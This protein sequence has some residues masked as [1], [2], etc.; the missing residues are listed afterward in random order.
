M[1]QRRRLRTSWKIITFALNLNYV[2]NMIFNSSNNYYI[3]SVDYK[4]HKSRTG[5]IG[6]GLEKY[7]VQLNRSFLNT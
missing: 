2:Y 7:P 1:T 5:N 6:T 3:G 4:I